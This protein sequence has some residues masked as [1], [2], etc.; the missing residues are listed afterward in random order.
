MIAETLG[1]LES[2]GNANRGDR[3]FVRY[4]GGMTSLLG[5]QDGRGGVG[6]PVVCLFTCSVCACDNKLISRERIVLKF[7]TGDC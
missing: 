3:K 5:Y 4:S 1:G 6:I 2:A 7:G